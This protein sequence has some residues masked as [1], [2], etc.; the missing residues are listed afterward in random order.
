MARVCQVTGKGVMVGN[1]VSHANNRTPRRFNPNLQQVRVLRPNGA[2]RRMRVCAKC[3][4][5][6][7]IAK[8]A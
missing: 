3:I 6:G 7:K 8:A 2:A 1:N 5:A 4:K